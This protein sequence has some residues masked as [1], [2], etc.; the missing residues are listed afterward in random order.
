MVMGINETPQIY[1][2]MTPQQIIDITAAI[3]GIP[4]EEITSRCR[5]FPICKARNLAAWGIKSVRPTWSL[6]RIANE[7]GMTDHGSARHA[8]IRCRELYASDANFRA[9]RDRLASALPT[10]TEPVTL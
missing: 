4:R 2:Q 6:I 7:L 9:M 1:N 3:T 8:L 10:L 5:E